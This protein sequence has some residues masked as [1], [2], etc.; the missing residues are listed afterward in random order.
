MSVVVGQLDG[1]R[2]NVAT[3]K[4]KAFRNTIRQKYDFSCGSAALA[5]LLK[6]HYQWP[7]DESQTFKGMYEHGNQASIQN[8]G[9]SMRDMKAYVEAEG[10]EANGYKLSL[11]ELEKLG[12]P[13]IVVLNLDGYRHFVVVK[14]FANGFVLVGD[15]AVGVKSYSREK[16]ETMWGHIAFLILNYKSVGQAH[17][18]TQA[19]WG[20]VTKGPLAAGVFNPNLANFSVT[21][22]GPNDFRF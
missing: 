9:F 4:E 18:N 8:T 11:E 17:F 19:D 20:S 7:V 1:F 5:T 13:A 16:F 6:Y 21:L 15:P 14:G 22:P 3:F 12:V 2:V 10:F